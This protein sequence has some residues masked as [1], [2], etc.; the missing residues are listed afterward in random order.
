MAILVSWSSK[1]MMSATP[2]QS[3]TPEPDLKA[4]LW[5][6]MLLS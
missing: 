3:Q 4:F 6:A 5:R 2:N 1:K